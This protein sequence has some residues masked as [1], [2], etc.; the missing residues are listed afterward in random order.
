MLTSVEP[1]SAPGRGSGGRE[2]RQHMAENWKKTWVRDFE[3]TESPK[4]DEEDDSYFDSIQGIEFG[5]TG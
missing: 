1:Q 5:E 2:G 4:R 3:P